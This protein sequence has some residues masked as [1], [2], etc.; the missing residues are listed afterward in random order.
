[1]E[2][3]NTQMPTQSVGALG[4]EKVQDAPVSE[5]T[6]EQRLQFIASLQT[7]ILGRTDDE[8][9]QKEMLD[10]ATEQFKAAP[11]NLIKD[12][13]PKCYGR[14]FTGYDT[15]NIYYTMCRRCFKGII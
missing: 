9:K 2:S 6:E 12:N 8:A 1:M 11:I 14:G 13:C 4:P 3:N 10:V 15:I 7:F 5:V